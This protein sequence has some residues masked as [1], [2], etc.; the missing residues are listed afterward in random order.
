MALTRS[1][2]R[3]AATTPVDARVMLM[4][5]ITANANGS[6][7]AGILGGANPSIV[8]ALPSMNVAIA[9]AEFVTTKGRADGVAIF[10]ND[11]TVNVPIDTAPPSNS[12]IDVIYVKHNDDTTGDSDAF[13]VFGVAKGTAAASPTKPSIP[14]GALELATLRVYSGTTATNGGSNTLVNTYQMTATRGGVVPFRTKADLDLWTTASAGQLASVLATGD[15]YTYQGV[16]WVGGARAFSAAQSIASGSGTVIDAVGLGPLGSIA[17]G[18]SITAARATRARVTLT[19]RYVS[20]GSG[21]GAYVGV[22]ASGATTVVPTSTSPRVATATQQVVNATET[23]GVSFL[24]DLNPGTTALDVVGQAF[25]PGGTRQIG[26]I[27]LVVEP[28]EG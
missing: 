28:I 4:G 3:N 11:G 14:T 2:I 9:P 1:L 13:P 19:F 15:T 12:R 8:S 25:G 26:Q 7:R 17:C 18:V 27:V 21:T 10:G 20:N 22:A 5:L 23:Y 16:S 24:M 6:P